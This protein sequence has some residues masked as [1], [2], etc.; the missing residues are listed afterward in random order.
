[1]H[2]NNIET[3]IQLEF[4]AN[5]SMHLENMHSEILTALIPN[6]GIDILS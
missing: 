3:S 5:F 2:A 6:N 4:V 1:M